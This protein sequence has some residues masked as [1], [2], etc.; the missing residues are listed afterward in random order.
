MASWF[1]QTKTV[2]S[3]SPVFLGSLY[4]LSLSNRQGF[5]K[6][7]DAQTAS[8]TTHEQDVIVSRRCSKGTERI[9]NYLCGLP[10]KLWRAEMRDRRPWLYSLRS[11]G[12]QERLGDTSLC[13]VLFTFQCAFASWSIALPCK[14]KMN[15]GGEKRVSIQAT[16]SFSWSLNRK[17]YKC[18]TILN[19]QDICWTYVN[20]KFIIFPV[21]S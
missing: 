16:N 6:F 14:C 4:H 19:I 13:T 7:R 21:L 20:S 9:A 11:Q 2:S 10:W 1:I 3:P 17:I 18:M 12:R 8:S 5:S 15:R